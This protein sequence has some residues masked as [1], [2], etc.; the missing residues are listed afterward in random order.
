MALYQHHNASADP[1][2]RIEKSEMTHVENTAKAT[3]ILNPDKSVSNSGK[4]ESSERYPGTGSMAVLPGGDVNAVTPGSTNKTLSQLPDSKLL[5]FLDKVLHSQ[6]FE[7][8]MSA[9]ILVNFGFVIVETDLVAD[10]PNADL[11]LFITAASW[12]ILG[13]FSVELAM[14]LFVYRNRFWRES[15]NN[16]DFAVVVT[17]ALFSI[18][19]LIFGE[20]FPV[21][22]LRILRLGKLA[23]VSKIFRVFPELRLMM[24]GLLGSLRAIFWGM[25]LLFFCVLVWGVIAVQF[26]HTV[27]L[28]VAD[29]GVYDR[30]GCERCPRAFATTANAVLTLTQQVVAGDA[31][32]EISMPV[33]EQNPISV[34]FFWGVYV[35]IGMAVL[36]LILG[37]V[38]NIAMQAHDDLK[39]EIEDEKLVERMEAQSHL[40]ALC[41]ELDAES[42]GSLSKEAIFD[43]YNN[44]EAFRETMNAMKIGE[45]DMEILWTI[46]DEE[47]TGKVCYNNFVSRCYGM[48]LSNTQFMLA[49]IRYYITQIRHYIQNQTSDV[50]KA[51]ANLAEDLEEEME[52]K[53]NLEQM[54]TGENSED[55]CEKSS[56]SHKSAFAGGKN[57]L[58]SRLSGMSSTS[59]KSASHSRH[60]SLSTDGDDSVRARGNSADS[61]MGLSQYSGPSEYKSCSLEYKQDDFTESI[62]DLKATLDACLQDAVKA[63]SRDEQGSSSEQ[64]QVASCKDGGMAIMHCSQN[65]P[66]A[67]VVILPQGVESLRHGADSLNARGN[68]VDSLRAGGAARDRVANS[69]RL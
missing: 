62:N 58:A 49:Y 34:V 3:D 55:I 47:K 48:K 27:N 44:S 24:A 19:G 53:A 46:L 35:T 6:V 14:R 23:R 66:A 1:V 20:L 7:Y 21:S 69:L 67:T 59:K 54:I 13:I 51:I 33:I 40:L 5:R 8:T 12:S 11:P 45:E 30:M 29:N 38:V 41:A 10:D 22:A 60:V 43:G 31:W 65:R 16:F 68:S 32:G 42:T 28:Q 39:I 25:V 61:S 63:L 4:S 52:E 64:R 2:A 56:K 26:V 9:V 18:F 17:D 37:V 50:T 36:N 57:S 15:W